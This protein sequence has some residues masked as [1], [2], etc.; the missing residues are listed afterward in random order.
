M[1]PAGSK[2]RGAADCLGWEDEFL[3][4]VCEEFDLVIADLPAVSSAASDGFSVSQLDGIL[5]VLQ[6]EKTSDIVAQKSLRR[7]KADGATVL[8]VV[9]NKCR[10]H[11]P[12]WI[13]KKLGD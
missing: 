10:I 5:V 12:R 13:D 8:G 1:L 6:A 7:I 4:T 2:T 9:L 11:L 3:D